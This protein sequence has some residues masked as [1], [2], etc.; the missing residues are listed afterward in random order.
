M[1]A[2]LMI[3]S[4]STSPSVSRV[5]PGLQV[6]NGTGTTTSSTASATNSSAETNA[7]QVCRVTGRCALPQRR[8]LDGADLQSAAP[9]LPGSPTHSD[10]RQGCSF[11]I[12]TSA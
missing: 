5:P 1:P 9:V 7:V 6:T 4:S 8:L 3:G 2:T 10:P 11:Q 12:G